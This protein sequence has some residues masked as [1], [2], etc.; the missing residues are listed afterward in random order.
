MKVSVSESSTF[1][2]FQNVHPT[3]QKTHIERRLHR[4]TEGA[5]LDWA[6][7]EALAFGSLLY[8]GTLSDVCLKC[9]SIC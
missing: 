4:M 5:D 6:T 1:I 7:A 8:Q 3:I 9:W 2:Y